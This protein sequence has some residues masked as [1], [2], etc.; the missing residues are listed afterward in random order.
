[1]KIPVI[2]KN[3]QEDNIW[4]YFKSSNTFY[5]SRYVVAP[6]WKHRFVDNQKIAYWDSFDSRSRI[7]IL[8]KFDRFCRNPEICPI[9]QWP[10]S[11]FPFDICLNDY[12]YVIVMFSAINTWKN[13]DKSIKIDKIMLGYMG[14]KSSG[15]P[16][17]FFDN[18]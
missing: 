10:I 11:F 4:Q 6:L 17:T 3:T 9:F 7:F 5:E 16:C 1:M 14:Q 8:T 2:G 15:T 12:G 18:L 13:K